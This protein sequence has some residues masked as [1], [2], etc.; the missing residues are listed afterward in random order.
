MLK[1]HNIPRTAA[2]ADNLGCNT[3]VT[4]TSFEIINKQ[5][6]ATAQLKMRSYGFSGILLHTKFNNFMI[7]ILLLLK[8]YIKV[9]MWVPLTCC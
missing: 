7:H 9:D 2:A 1:K 8:C 6:I 4:V 5:L 3:N